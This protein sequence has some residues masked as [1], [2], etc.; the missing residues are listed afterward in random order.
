MGLGPSPF[1][2]ARDVLSVFWFR[3]LTIGVL[4]ALVVLAQTVAAGTLMYTMAHS[5]SLPKFIT[6]IFSEIENTSVMWLPIIAFVFAAL[7]AY[8]MYLHSLIAV[9]VMVDYEKKCAERLIKILQSDSKLYKTLTDNQIVTLISKDCRFGGRIAYEFSTMVMPL[10]VALGGFPVLFYINHYATISLLIVMTLAFSGQAIVWRMAKKVSQ[11]MESDAAFD[12]IAKADLLKEL[13]SISGSY[14]EITAKVPDP[15]FMNT[16]R[17]RLTMPHMGNFLG[18]LLYALAT[19]VIMFWFLVFPQKD[20]V[21]GGLMFYIFV[22]I[23]VLSRLRI[24]PK[25]FTNF[26]VFFNYFGRAFYIIRHGKLPESLK[27]KSSNEVD[28]TPLDEDY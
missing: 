13:K 21:H 15:I 17:R 12:R 14:Q 6:N 20:Q 27:A 5:L 26:H 28:A 7:S 23:F 8:L 16:Y 11:D 18:G 25:V 9:S 19:A 10:G 2:V 4:S 22:A 24:A 1:I 3:L